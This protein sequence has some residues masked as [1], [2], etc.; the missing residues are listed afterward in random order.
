MISYYIYNNDMHRV[1]LDIPQIFPQKVVNYQVLPTLYRHV[2][3]VPIID[4]P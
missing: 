4:L 1:Y 2:I 3:D